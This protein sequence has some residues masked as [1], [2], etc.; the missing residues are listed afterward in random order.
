VPTSI[1]TSGLTELKA[2]FT[3][4]NTQNYDKLRLY[5][6]SLSHSSQKSSL[7]ILANSDSSKWPTRGVY[8]FKLEHLHRNRLGSV[9]H[10]G[11][12]GYCDPK[13]SCEYKFLILMKDVNKLHFEFNPS[14]EVET[15]E[16]FREYFDEVVSSDKPKVFKFVLDGSLANNDISIEFTPIRGSPQVFVNPESLPKKLEESVWKSDTT[17]NGTVQKII[18]TKEE[19]NNH[20]TKMGVGYI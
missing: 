12:V 19:R 13:K 9:R 7:D 16:P 20:L 3:F 5:A 17:Y 8:D 4:K 15:M 10:K 18:I 11:D 2:L 1:Y 14:Q 6:Q